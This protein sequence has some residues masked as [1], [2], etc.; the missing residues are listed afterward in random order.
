MFLGIL[1]VLSKRKK[2]NNII[3]AKFCCRCI[4]I[5]G[6]LY[7]TCIFKQKVSVLKKNK[8][9]TLVYFLSHQEESCIKRQSWNGI[10]AQKYYLASFN[11]YFFR[12]C[13]LPKMTKMVSWEE[14]AHLLKN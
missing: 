7:I 3:N 4:K 1:K 11:Y 2:L 13:H 14:I 8:F 5:F 10:Y 12:K 9:H 6:D